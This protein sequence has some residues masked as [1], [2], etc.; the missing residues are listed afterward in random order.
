MKKNILAQKN[1]VQEKM[2]KPLKLDFDEDLISASLILTKKVV[3]Y[4]GSLVGAKNYR[5]LVIPF[6]FSKDYSIKD[7]IHRLKGS[8]QSIYAFWEELMTVDFEEIIK[9]QVPILFCEGRN[10][11][12]VSSKLVADYSKTLTSANDIVW[13]ERSAHFPQWE[14][15]VKFNSVIKEK[16]L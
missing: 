2:N 16:C 14:E 8:K 12:H 11:F 7:L 4:G 13:F 3:A 9:F 1:F 10:D 15:P 5:K 6:I